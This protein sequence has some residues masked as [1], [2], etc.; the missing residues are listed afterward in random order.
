MNIVNKETV[1]GK[2][3]GRWNYDWPKFPG[4]QIFRV[5]PSDLMSLFEVGFPKMS[6]QKKFSE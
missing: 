6:S 3:D 5:G 2:N 4:E 1:S